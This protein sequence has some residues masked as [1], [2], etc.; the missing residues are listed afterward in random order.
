MADNLNDEVKEVGH[1]SSDPDAKTNTAMQR[2]IT[3]EGINPE[4]TSYVG[5]DG[6]WSEK[7]VISQG[8]RDD[9]LHDG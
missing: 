1:F 9:F 4:R 5:T 6:I 3:Q 2:L 8:G 7:W